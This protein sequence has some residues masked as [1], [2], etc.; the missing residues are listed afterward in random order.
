M[1]LNNQ[2]S[3]LANSPGETLKLGPVTL[4]NSGTLQAGLGGTLAIGGNTDQLNLTNNPGP[5]GQGG[6]ILSNQGGTVTLNNVSVTGGFLD[7][8]GSG[9][10]NGTGPVR[11]G[12]LTVNGTY[13]VG[14]GTTTT[15]GGTVRNNGSINVP[16]GGTLN[17]STLINGNRVRAALGA[18]VTLNSFDQTDGSLLADGSITTPLADLEGGLI[19]GTGTLTGTLAMAGTYQPGDDSAPGIFSVI[20]QYN[21]TASG[22]LDELLGGTAPGSFSQTLIT[23]TST[24]AGLLGVS[25]YGGFQPSSSDVFPIMLSTSGFSGYFADAIPSAPGLPGLLSYSGGTFDVNYNVSWNGG[26]AVT[27]SNFTPDSSTTPEPASFLLV[28]MA[29]IAAGLIIRWGPARAGARA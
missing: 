10:I 15:I 27:L 5:G 29:L 4:T 13:N 28:G 12:S 16:A 11:L 8:L 26:L 18:A 9:V 7:T 3:I 17:G 2:S 22:I 25:L 21:Q 23:G 6:A 24:L 20:G 19:T 1:G 14:A